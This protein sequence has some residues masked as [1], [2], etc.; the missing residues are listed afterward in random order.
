[1]FWCCPAWWG[2]L[3]GSCKR[4]YYNGSSVPCMHGILH[5]SLIKKHPHEIGYLLHTLLSSSSFFLR[6]IMTTPYQRNQPPTRSQRLPPGQHRNLTPPSPHPPTRLIQQP[7][8]RIPPMSR[9]RLPPQPGLDPQLPRHQ[10]GQ[11]S[12]RPCPRPHHVYAVNL[13]LQR[14]G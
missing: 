14:G 12:I 7:P 4:G 2:E 8:R 5:Q 6:P 3:F 13:R 11:I 9:I 10:P 1:M